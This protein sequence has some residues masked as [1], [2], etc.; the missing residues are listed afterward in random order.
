MP[1]GTEMHAGVYGIGERDHIELQ[2]RRK[3]IEEP[4]GLRGRTRLF[5]TV[6]HLYSSLTGHA[7]RRRLRALCAR[8][9]RR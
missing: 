2:R 1:S 7:H 6:N 5:V 8:I 3:D 9:P 4:A